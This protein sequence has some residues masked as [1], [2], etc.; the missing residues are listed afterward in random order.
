MGQMPEL[1]SALLEDGPMTVIS[2]D[3]KAK[4]ALDALRVAS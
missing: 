3:L 1:G 4:V 2:V